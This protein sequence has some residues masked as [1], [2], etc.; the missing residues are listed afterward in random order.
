MELHVLEQ[1]DERVT[2]ALDGAG[3]TFS[4]NLKHELYN[5]KQVDIAAYKV[6]HPLTGTPTFIIQKDKA[7][8]FNKILADATQRIKDA[9]KEFAQAL[10]K[11]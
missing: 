1:S 4:N 2:F 11:L 6:D 3:H 8:K 7:A 9:N 5:D 10:K